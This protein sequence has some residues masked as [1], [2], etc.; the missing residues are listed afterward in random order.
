MEEAPKYPALK[1][2]GRLALRAVGIEFTV[3]T[4]DELDAYMESI[5]VAEAR[6]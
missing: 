1:E 5:R 4:Q 6:A 2:L 3:L